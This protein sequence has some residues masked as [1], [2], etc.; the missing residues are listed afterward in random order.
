LIE[1]IDLDGSG[2]VEFGEFLEIFRKFKLNKYAN[3]K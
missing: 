3:P 2:E 1:A